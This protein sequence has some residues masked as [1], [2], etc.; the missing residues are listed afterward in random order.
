M[1]LSSYEVE[2]KEIEEKI[3]SFLSVEGSV[4]LD[5]GVG[6]YAE[7]TRKLIDMGAAVIGVDSDI[8]VLKNHTNLP[9]TFVQCDIRN[10][11]FKPHTA[12]AAVFY[13]ILHEVDPTF[14]ETIIEQVAVISRHILIV[15][16]TPGKSPAYRK[17][18]ELWK[19]A[20]HA[21]G[22]FEDYR[23]LSYW[24]TLIQAN[25][26][27]V[28]FSKTIEHKENI[29]S[30]VIE[31]IVHSTIGTWREHSV[32]EECSE[33]MRNFS[34]YAKKKGMKWSDVAVVIGESRT[35]HE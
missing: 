27:N 3:W 14:H 25:Q 16:P 12:G 13:F 33:K 28:L 18:A 32:P 8:T 11:P 34:E 26:W 35:Y 29:P 22:A 1:S 6:Q 24:E 21:V 17:Y 31:R 20:M 15:E 5:F 7:S 9:A 2:Q 4:V 30:E 10:I 19:E 23:P